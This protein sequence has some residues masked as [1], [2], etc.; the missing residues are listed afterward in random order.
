MKATQFIFR[1]LLGCAVVFLAWLCI[2]SVVTPI[3]FEE[4]RAQRETAV[5]KN[6]VH[7]RA[8]ESE[9]KLE[10]GYF[11]TD[12]DS[13]ILFLQTA[14]KKE[15]LKEGALTDKQLEA[16][17]TEH[18]A[19]KI[20]ER[21]KIKAKAQLRTDNDSLIYAYIWEKDREVINNGLQGFRRDTI[22]KNMIQTLYKG[23]YTA[24]NIASI[25]TIP[26]SNGQR[27][28]L[29]ANNNYTTPQGIRIPIMEA[30]AH[31][32]TYLSD[33]DKQELVNLIDK[34]EKLEHFPGLK[35]GSIDAPN[36]NAGNWE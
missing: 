4:T 27:F 18:K 1:L 12:L 15:V 33:L 21:A 8:A 31:F 9:F 6:L 2:D 32:N 7:L 25:T 5:I 34:E 13:L 17:M 16:G 28:T 14:P 30:S 19:V 3:R 36:N 23:E 29:E 24:D 20:I 22:Y 35:F 26:Y 10:K 11:T